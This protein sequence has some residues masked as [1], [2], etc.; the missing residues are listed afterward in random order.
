MNEPSAYSVHKHPRRR[1]SSALATIL[2][3]GGPAYKKWILKT[4]FFFLQTKIQPPRM[5][6]SQNIPLDE[7]N[8]DPPLSL[9][10]KVAQ[11]MIRLVSHPSTDHNPTA[12]R[13]LAFTL[14]PPLPVSLYLSGLL[15]GPNNLRQQ[16]QIRRTDQLY[17][18][19]VWG[20]RFSPPP[21]R[22]TLDWPRGLEQS[23]RP[24]YA[25]GRIS[26]FCKARCVERAEQRTSEKGST[27]VCLGSRGVG[28]LSRDPLSASRTRR[29]GYFGLVCFMFRP[30]LSI[31]SAS[32]G[33]SDSEQSR[34]G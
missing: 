18:C 12:C 24:R 16:N 5:R 31:K 1:G 10:I 6:C 22:K 29:C 26:G 4:H 28:M 23:L 34:L 20:Y 2:I 11:R 25:T 30:W 8:Q 15:P 33:S 14:S 13:A 3:G 7:N 32:A 9:C 19:G 21:S 27:R 17:V